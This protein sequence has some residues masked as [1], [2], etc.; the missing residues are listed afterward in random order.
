[1][2][3][4]LLFFF[5]TN[6]T[7]PSSTTVDAIPSHMHSL[8]ML[9][10]VRI[11]RRRDVACCQVMVLAIAMPLRVNMSYSLLEI[12]DLAVVVVGDDDD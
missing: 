4:L 6:R 11:L 12:S 7:A 5:H 1:M 10:Q 8:T 3:L 2:V 9:Q